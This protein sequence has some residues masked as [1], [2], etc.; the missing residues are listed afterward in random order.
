[1]ISNCLVYLLCLEL[2]CLGSHPVADHAACLTELP[3]R[4]GPHTSSESLLINYFLFPPP[5]KDP[6]LPM[7]SASSSTSP[8]S[9]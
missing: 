1:M 4:P 2:G 5:K 8:D 6:S 7:K 9:K 3:S